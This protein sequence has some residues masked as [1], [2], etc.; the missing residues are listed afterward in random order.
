MGGSVVAGASLLAP[1]ARALG[2]NN[3]IRM[4]FAGYRGRGKHLINLFSEVEGVR[5]AALCDVDQKV[6]DER[7]EVLKGRGQRV[8]AYTDIRK[9]L[10]DNTID[11]VVGAPPNHWHS[12]MG[13]GACPA[14]RGV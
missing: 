9:L 12:L 11:A 5:V 6:L 8:T 13:I 2:A 10:D 7:V 4:G 1:H 14:G 3:D